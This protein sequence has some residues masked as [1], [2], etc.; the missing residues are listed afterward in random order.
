MFT[1]DQLNDLIH[2]R[3]VE[4]VIDSLR[5]PK[6][7]QIEAK[8]IRRKNLKAVRSKIGGYLK[9]KAVTPLKNEFIN[10]S[11]NK[12][13]SSIRNKTIHKPKVKV[14]VNLSPEKR[15]LLKRSITQNGEIKGTHSDHSG[16]WHS[17]DRKYSKFSFPENIIDI[18]KI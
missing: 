4:K 13:R 18:D 11:I 8:R 16:S 17:P 15:L 10:I 5:H 9:K 12:S 2:K 6:P 3:R 1:K 14:D 7:H